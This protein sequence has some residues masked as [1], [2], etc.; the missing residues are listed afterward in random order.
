MLLRIKPV[1]VID[2]KELPEVTVDRFPV[3]GD[4]L[5]INYEMYY[6]CDT[7]IRK[8]TGLQRIG[9]IPLVIKNPKEVKNMDQYL[10]YLSF[11]HRRLQGGNVS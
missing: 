5:E 3:N 7:N 11:A 1:N 2:C 6:V 9:V 4:P 8:K 10:K